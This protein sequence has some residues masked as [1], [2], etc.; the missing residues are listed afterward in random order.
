ML[1]NARNGDIVLF[2]DKVDGKNQTVAALKTI[3]PKLQQ[4]GYRFV[5]VSELLAMKAK[6]AGKD[7]V[8]FK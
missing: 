4:E 2:H 5:T 7:G 3:L 1:K 8:S 6:E